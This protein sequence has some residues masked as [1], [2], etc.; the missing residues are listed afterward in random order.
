MLFTDE[1]FVNIVPQ[2]LLERGIR[3]REEYGI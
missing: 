1:N 2:D 3:L